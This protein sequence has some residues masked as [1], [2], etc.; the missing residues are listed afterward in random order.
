[1]IFV[2]VLV[3]GLVI[4]SFLN[5]CIAR[6]PHER[7]I[8]SPPSHCPRCQTPIRWYDNVPIVSFF[9]LRGRCRKCGLPISWRYPLVELLNGI[10]YVWA[11]SAFG[12]SGETALAML[13]CSA[14]IVITFI[15]LDHQII[16]DVIT[17]PGMVIGLIAAPFFMSA[18]EPPLALGLG[19]VLPQASTYL[20]GFINSL[21]GLLLG[22]APLFLIGWIWEKL[23]KVEAMGGGDV[24][25][26]GMVGSFLGWKGAFLTI[27]LGALTGSVA[28]VALILFKKHQADKVIPFGPYLALG[29]LLTLFLGR[30]I[31]TW[32]FGM[33]YP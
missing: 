16:P 32:Y 25:F 7:S 17:L 4:G 29:T 6:L 18:L 2:I 21:V 28:G 3:F 10:L 24:K 15:D 19:R 23:R 12:L 8:V 30:D 13:L 14:L 22:A 9:I 33:L 27:M 20:T 1:M 5:V 26:M 11:F 31:M